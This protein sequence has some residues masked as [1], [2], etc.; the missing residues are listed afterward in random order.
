MRSRQALWVAHEYRR[1][2]SGCSDDKCK[3][4]REDEA[5]LGRGKIRF[6]E[7]KAS[8]GKKSAGQKKDANISR[9]ETELSERLGAQ[10]VIKHSAKGKGE[11]KIHYNS[12]DEL[13]GI[14]KH[15]K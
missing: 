12:S 5:L 4:D 14:L 7:G 10:V 13:D 11:L 1:G 6:Q 9:L 3:W 15:I 2:L 8:E